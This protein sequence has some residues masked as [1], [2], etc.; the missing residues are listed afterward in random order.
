MRKRIKNI[1][2]RMTDSEYE[3]LRYKSAIAG[4]SMQEYLTKAV[5]NSVITSQ[6]LNDQLKDICLIMRDIDRQLKGVATNI[7]QMAHISNATA[8]LSSSEN[9]TR[10]VANIEELRKEQNKEWL[11]LRQLIE[12]HEI[13]MKA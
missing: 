7:N 2:F 3:S 6:E 12:A 11:Y 13:P 4:L 5:Q 1:P 10:L 9:L 8:S